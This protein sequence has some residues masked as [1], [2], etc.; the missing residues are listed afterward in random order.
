MAG[1]IQ[2]QYQDLGQAANKFK[3]ESDQTR[4]LYQ[5]VSQCVQ[6]LQGGDWIGKGAQNFFREMNDL[7]NPGMQ[8][9]VNALNDA[10]SATQRIVQAFQQAENEAGGIFRS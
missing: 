1:K 2:C 3:Q 7:V 10:S 5:K 6:Q 8:R 4:Q 9:L